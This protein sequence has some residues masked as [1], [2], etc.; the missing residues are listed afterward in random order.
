MPNI[1]LGKIV[2][3]FQP[4]T[5]LS[6]KLRYKWKDPTLGSVTYTEPT[7]SIYKEISAKT[8]RNLP[9]KIANQ[10][11]ANSALFYANEST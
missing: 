1:F 2:I 9:D 10:V 3:Q 7:K 4:L 6:E 5:I 11:L 8:I